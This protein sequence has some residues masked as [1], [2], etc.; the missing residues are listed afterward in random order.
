[1]CANLTTIR[2]TLARQSKVNIVIYDMTLRPVRVLVD[3]VA[4][5]PGKKAIEWDGTS[6]AGVDLARG[7]YFCQI[8]VTDEI[9]PEY[10]ILKLALTR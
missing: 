8:I 7:I 2:Y 1:M 3:G 9:E 4:E 6:S 5:Q 10:A